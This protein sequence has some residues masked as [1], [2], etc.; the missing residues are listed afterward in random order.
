MRVGGKRLEK[1]NKVYKRKAQT[2][3]AQSSKAIGKYR[4]EVCVVMVKIYSFMVSKV[5]RKGRTNSFPGLTTGNFNV[6][7]CREVT[8]LSS[9]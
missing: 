9:G 2:L 6:F 7:P 8:C 4:Q 5:T 1:S 3:K